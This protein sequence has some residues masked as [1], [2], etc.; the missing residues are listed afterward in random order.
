MT[1]IVLDCG[2]PE[3]SQ[4]VSDDHSL[5]MKGLGRPLQVLERLRAQKTEKSSIGG[6]DARGGSLRVGDQAGICWLAMVAGMR[7][8][9]YQEQEREWRS[10]GV[11]V[12]G[13]RSRSGRVHW[14]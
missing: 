5:R 4:T 2:E 12:R 3:I 10:A 9:R 6:E 7:S 8:S 14:Q 13:C 1:D 11:G